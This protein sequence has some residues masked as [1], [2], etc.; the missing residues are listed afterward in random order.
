MSLYQKYRAKKFSEILTQTHVKDVLQNSVKNGSFGHAYL[1]VGTRGTGKTSL[2][3][4]FARALN[5]QNLDHVK[6]TGEPCNECES[7]TFS[8]NS[9]HTDIIEMDAASN[10]GIDEVRNLKEAVDFLPS[11]GKYKVY[12]IDEAH[13]MTKE[14]F[15]ALLKTIEEPPKHIV[16]I[17]CTTE[18]FKVP[19][20]IVSRSQV[21]ELRNASIDEIVAKVTHI[22]EHEGVDIDHEGKKLIAKLGK[23][24]FRDTESILEKV[25]HS[26]NEKKLDLDGV[27]SA[28]GLSS[29]MLIDAV[30]R[31]VYEKNLK[32]LQA[33]LQNELDEGSVTTFN[34]QLAESIYQ[35]I[36][37]NLAENQIDAFKYEVFDFLASIDKELRNTTNPRLVYIAKL[38][39]FLKNYS[40]SSMVMVS[41][42]AVQMQAAPAQQTPQSGNVYTDDEPT[43][44]NPERMKKNPSELLRARMKRTG[45]D[46]AGDAASQS[47]EPS[48]PPQKYVSKIDFLN[49]MKEKNM[50]LFR[51]FSTHE[52]QI[53]KHRLIVDVERKLEKDLLLRTQTID[54]ISTF[55]AQHGVELKIEF[56]EPKIDMRRSEEKQVAEI[57]KTVA[58]LSEDEI[59]K[60]FKA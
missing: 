28:L 44:I 54:L 53:E 18:L 56:G 21:F 17:M 57:Q 8:L 16:F 13:M 2:A 59:G 49:Y 46:G 41:T 31:S 19:P 25:I 30:K 42:P 15:N 51:F 58:D 1:F 24:S 27:V 23:G 48:A 10:R 12:I 14:A 50:F 47:S 40:G 20:T 29:V 35:D 39:N 11:I 34:Y 55:S 7:C 60:I 33:T 26:A 4:I 38:L 9:S 6:E 5:C 37:E 45:T 32:T 36:V 3:R 43:P 52:F 22:L